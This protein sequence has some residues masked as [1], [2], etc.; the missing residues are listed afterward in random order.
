MRLSQVMAFRQ[1]TA[2]PTG[3]AQGIYL[4]KFL[5]DEMF[6]IYLSTIKIVIQIIIPWPDNQDHGS[7]FE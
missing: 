4:T 5:F 6:I 3:N 7:Q 2:G 1:L